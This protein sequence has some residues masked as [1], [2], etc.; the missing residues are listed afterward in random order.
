MLSQLLSVTFMILTLY[1]IE[2]FANCNCKS[3]VF[4]STSRCV[5]LDQTMYL[6]AYNIFVREIPHLQFMFQTE[7]FKGNRLLIRL[8]SRS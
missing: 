6:P 8:K 3:Y 2:F 4:P 1:L 7:V 5:K